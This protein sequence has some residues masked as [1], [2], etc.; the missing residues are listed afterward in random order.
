MQGELYSVLMSCP[1]ILL[2]DS[3]CASTH[4]RTFLSFRLHTYLSLVFPAHHLITYQVETIVE[5][6]VAVPD[7][8]RVELETEISHYKGLLKETESMLERLQVRN[9][10]LQL[11][12]FFILNSVFESKLAPYFVVSLYARFFLN[13]F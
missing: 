6:P 8:S 2:K 10:L 13:H 11:S 5:V 1:L 4:G 3:S 7:S 9:V 12:A